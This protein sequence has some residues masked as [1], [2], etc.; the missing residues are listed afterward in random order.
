MKKKVQ[1][2][3]EIEVD[4]KEVEF[5]IDRLS[6]ILLMQIEQEHA[7]KIDKNSKTC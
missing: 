1:K 3:T 5:F 6:N 7:K 2:E 4:E